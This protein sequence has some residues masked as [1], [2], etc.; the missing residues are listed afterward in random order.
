V[1]IDIFLD[2]TSDPQTLASRIQGATK[3]NLSLQLITNRGTRVWP[4][5]LS[6]TRCVDHWRC[7]FKAKSSRAGETVPPEVRRAEVLGLLACLDE[8]G[9]DVIKTE[10]LFTFDGER[11][12]SLGQGEG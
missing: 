11:R 8:A 3:G 12:Y 2:A 1:G 9:L 6:E 4:D 7:R 10:N 5:V